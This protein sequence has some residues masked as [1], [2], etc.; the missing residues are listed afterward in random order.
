M[1]AGWAWFLVSWLPVSGVIQAGGQAMAGRYSYLPMLGVELALLWTGREW[2]APAA[3]R[4]WAA[5][6]GAVLLALAACTWRQLG[7]WQ[8]SFTL[9]DHTLAV[10]ESNGVAFNNRGFALCDMG[11]MD[12]GM[13]DFRRA[14]AINPAHAEANNNLGRLLTQQGRAADAV[15]L[16]RAA[17]REKPSSLE[18]APDRVQTLN[19]LANALAEMGR[20]DDTVAH[21]RH[22]PRK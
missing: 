16:L 11:R 12:E 19:N 3:R 14:L 9:F 5:G 1:L 6:A 4:A 22:A 8:N 18:L 20:L 10:T 17:V 15:P 13:A 2:I 7:V 21:H